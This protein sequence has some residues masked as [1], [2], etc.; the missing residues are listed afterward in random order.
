MIKTVSHGLFF[1]ARKAINRFFSMFSRVKEKVIGVDKRIVVISMRKRSFRDRRKRLKQ[2]RIREQAE[3]KLEQRVGEVS[4][5]EE[6][7]VN[8]NYITKTLGDSGDLITRCFTVQATPDRKAAVMYIDGMA[9]VRIVDQ[10]VLSPAM[11]GIEIL[12]TKGNLMELLQESFIQSGEVKVTSKMKQLI[13]ALLYGDT[14]FFL[15]G[16]NKGIIV[17]TKGW[18]QRGVDEPK[19][20]AVIRGPREGFTEN[21]R[22]N[23]A[24][25]RRRLQDPDLRLKSLTVGERT[26]THLSLLYIEGV[27]DQ[28]VVQEMEK[29]IDQISIDGVLESGY[30]E[31]MIQDNMWSPFPLIQNTERPDAVVAHLLEGKVALLVDGTPHVL[32]APAVFAQ[33]YYSPEDYY[34]R[35]LVSSFLRFLRLGSLVIALLL[36]AFYIAFVSFHSE[37]IPV[38][39]AIA[40]AAGRAGVPFPSIVEALVMEISVEVLREASTR[41]P[42][43]IGPTIGIV[44]ALVIGEAAVSAQLV[45]P[46]MVI[47]VGL[48]T[49]SSYANPN[50]NAAISLRLLRF[51]L[52]IAA[53][54]LGLYGVMLLLLLIILHLV[55]LRSFG[56]PYMAPIA[57]LR[58]SD[59]KDSLVRVPWPFMKKRPKIFR[60]QDEKRQQGGDDSI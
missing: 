51:P 34:E 60:P 57:P 10:F 13:E 59:L 46:L 43:P 45:S 17:G 2:E 30:I 32:I 31:E 50:Y 40:M 47:V 44:G 5:A 38:K 9:D 8:I 33:F 25:I 21:L 49:I 18:D 42:G 39:M 16:E 19:T 54:T 14:L 23:S 12:R 6:L 58:W 3:K 15:D 24:L 1:M 22:T 28:A 37:M 52:M 4:V 7:E 48:T 20:A 36:P 11:T 53:A 26:K 35:Y 27:T 41:L 55:K 56:V 29:R